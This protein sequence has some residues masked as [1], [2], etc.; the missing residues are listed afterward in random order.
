MAW[1]KWKIWWRTKKK[2]R[3]SDHIRA[4]FLIVFEFGF[5]KNKGNILVSDEELSIM[6]GDL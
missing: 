2:H 5:K 6:F 1:L 3:L 4:F